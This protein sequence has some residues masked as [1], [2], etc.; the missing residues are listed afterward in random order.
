MGD[1]ETRLPTCLPVHKSSL[2]E[3]MTLVEPAQAKVATTVLPKGGFS[4]LNS[5]LSS[6][7]LVPLKP[8]RAIP[9]AV[10]AAVTPGTAVRWLGGVTSPEQPATSRAMTSNRLD[11]VRP[12]CGKD[13]TWR[14]ARHSVGAAATVMQKAKF[15]PRCALAQRPRS[16][17]FRG[18]AVYARCH[19]RCGGVPQRGSFAN[20]GSARRA[21]R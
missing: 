16:G 5:L 9:D 3:S 6:V 13:A 8:H 11:V 2:T 15:A 1:A 4:G 14:T 17:G 10:A 20:R 19:G 12:P 18:A 21:K 7:P